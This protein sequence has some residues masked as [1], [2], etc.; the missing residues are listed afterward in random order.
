MRIAL[1]LGT[2]WPTL[3]A[4]ME[5]KKRSPLGLA[6]IMVLA[7]FAPLTQACGESKRHLET[8]SGGQAGSS[9]AA[10]GGSSQGGDGPAVT[11][12]AGGGGT[13]ASHAG[14]GGSTNSGSGGATPQGHAGSTAGVTVGGATM[15]ESGSSD[16]AEGGST[17]DGGAGA[18][19]V[20]GFVAD[21][22]PR[23]QAALAAAAPTWTCATTLPAVPVADGDAVRDVVRGFIADA[24]DVAPAD[25]TM[26]T[27]ECST[28]TT[29]TCAEVF[30]HDTASTGGALYD[31][32]RP[33]A[34]ELQANTTDVEVSVWVPMKDGMSLPPVFVMTGISDG[35]LVGMAV[36]NTPDVCN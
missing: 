25:I 11:G 20:S 17:S 13:G 32:V 35:V 26:M 28:P 7:V 24:L 22:V 34:Q 18:G 2:L 31:T 8:G 16:A 5:R 9:A 14:I 12:R 27:E 3:L 23:A 6:S 15:G 10:S 21:F 19:P 4:V 29:T 33:L 36:F 1:A 30:A